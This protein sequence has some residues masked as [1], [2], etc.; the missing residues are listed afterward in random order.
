MNRAA[1][2]VMAAALA[3][4]PARAR[5]YLH[6]ASPAELP[7][8]TEIEGQVC[9]WRIEDPKAQ[10][11]YF[12]KAQ[13]EPEN[14]SAAVRLE[15]AASLPRFS[16]DPA[17][18][19]L[20]LPAA[21]RDKPWLQGPLDRPSVYV[22]AATARSQIDAG[23]AW[24]RVFQ[25]DDKTKPLYTDNADGC[26]HG[27]AAHRFL[28]SNKGGKPLE[29]DFAYRPFWRVTESG[30]RADD[31]PHGAVFYPGDVV[32]MSLTIETDDHLA[33]RI[34]TLSSSTGGRAPFEAAF[35]A[36]GFPRVVAR[37]EDRRVFKRVNALDQYRFDRSAGTISANEGTPALP[38]QARARGGVWTAV[39]L[40]D[41][42][43]LETPLAGGGCSIVIS[44]ADRGAC[45]PPSVEAS[46]PKPDG[47]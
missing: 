36:G 18:Q 7:R 13:S 33:L 43:G 38:T 45:L 39:K 34:E 17:R 26:D 44:G 42:R 37:V 16:P 4:F 29:P 21:E 9:G 40:V 8:P 2:G 15:G 11:S 25:D 41:A 14:G 10:G 28:E 46:A 6:E 22:G 1:L 24:T 35:P 27:D 20:V 23:L 47:G 30:G 5:A 31:T 19:A 32:A 3:A 12:R